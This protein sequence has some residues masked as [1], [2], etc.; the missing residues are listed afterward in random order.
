MSENING[1]TDKTYNELLPNQNTKDKGLALLTAIF[2]DTEE[3]P[4]SPEEINFVN[5]VV[6]P[7]LE[8]IFNKP[9]PK[10]TLWR[11][12]RRVPKM[13]TVSSPFKKAFKKMYLVGMGAISERGNQCK[14]NSI[15]QS[16]SSTQ[17]KSKSE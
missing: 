5:R 12:S 14:S 6:Y 10:R 17:P 1:F 13:R 15:P 11:M 3:H 9:I 8:Q 7:L 16:K 2:S 4:P